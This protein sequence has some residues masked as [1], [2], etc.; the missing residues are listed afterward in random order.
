MTLLEEGEPWSVEGAGAVSLAA[1]KYISG[2]RRVALITG[3]NRDA[4][5]VQIQQRRVQLAY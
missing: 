2:A 1:L 3:G 5:P 4:H